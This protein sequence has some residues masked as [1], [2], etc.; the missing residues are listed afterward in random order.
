MRSAHFPV[1]AAH[2][3]AEAK[4]MFVKANANLECNSRRYQVRERCPPRQKSRVEC[5]KT[6]LETLVTY[7]TVGSGRCC[8]RCWQ[9]ENSPRDA[10]PVLE[11]TFSVLGVL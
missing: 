4:E 10:T 9:G 11:K 5:L 8:M 1:G 6:K 2:L 3:E 7:V